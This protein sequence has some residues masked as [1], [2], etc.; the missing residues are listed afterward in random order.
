MKKVE[1]YV[2]RKYLYKIESETIW[3]W[4]ASEK[5][6]SKTLDQTPDRIDQLRKF[7]KATELDLLLIG[8]VD[9]E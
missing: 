1:Y 7:N 8:V 4:V 5:H 2:S 9:Y 3:F 6:F